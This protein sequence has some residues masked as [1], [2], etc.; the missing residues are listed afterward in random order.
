MPCMSMAS[1][2]WSLDSRAKAAH[3]LP[4]VARQVAG[5]SA[6]IAELYA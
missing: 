4:I 1:H 5:V 3:R 6:E 2:A